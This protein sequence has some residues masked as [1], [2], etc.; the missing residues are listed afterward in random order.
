M[1]GLA[2]GFG[3]SLFC[4]VLS[5]WPSRN[6]SLSKENGAAVGARSNV[7]GMYYISQDFRPEHSHS[8]REIFSPPGPSH[9]ML[10]W[11]TIEKLWYKVHATHSIATLLSY[12][13]RTS[14][15]LVSHHPSPSNVLCL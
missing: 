6:Q 8:E 12:R 9:N 1:G 5:L 3:R 13:P 11:W 4:Y 7:T 10:R 14:I 15:D 2:A